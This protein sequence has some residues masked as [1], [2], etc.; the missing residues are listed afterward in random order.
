MILKQGA[1]GTFTN[2]EATEIALRDLQKN[3]FPMEQISLIGRE[4][5]NEVEVTGV[6][7]SENLLN[8]GNL[9]TDKNKA[10]EKATDGAIA[11]ITLG[12]FT[13]LLVG[14]GALV[15]PGMGPIMLAGAGATALATTLSGGVIG[16]AIGSLA[17]GLVGLGIPADRAK[18]YGD[19]VSE[20]KYLIIVEGANSE[21][22]IAEK[23]F[24]E[25]DIHDWYVYDS[26]DQS[27]HTQKPI[28]PDPDNDIKG[29][30][31]Q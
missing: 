6:N 5:N 13:G 15:I 19:L 8:V 26:P 30:Q 17:G 3:N 27:Q 31:Y 14:L 18:V 29:R 11:G 20:G 24:K 28:S 9:S 25:H 1:V 22:A 21:I 16:G 23:I 7:T 4:I 2:Y 10:P 12:G